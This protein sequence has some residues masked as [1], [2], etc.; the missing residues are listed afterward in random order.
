[1][2]LL[3]AG[4]GRI[5]PLRATLDGLGES[6]LVVGGD[7]LWNVHVHV[8]DVGAAVEA[9]VAAGRPH[10]IRVTHLAAGAARAEGRRVVAV[11]VGDG[12]ATLFQESAAV[13]VPG[14]AGRRASIAEVLDGIRRTVA[15]EVVVLPNDADSLAVAEAAARAARAEGVR[16]AV[17]PSR[18]SVQALAALAVHEPHR[19][20]DDDVVSMTAA[21][22]HARHG[23]V[24]VATRDGVTMA[25]VCSTGDVLGVIDGD[26]AVIG[27]R[28]DATACT[29]VDRLLGGGG[30]LVTLLVGADAEDSL[31]AAVVEH[32][33]RTRP[34]VETVVYAGGQPR[35]PL[36][37]GVE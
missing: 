22:G 1:M 37:V 31:A 3:D 27:A 23:G 12:L 30:E 34:E 13:V 26:F 8:D 4:E 19:L 10:R 29:V 2:Y 9:G 21:A 35:Y 20:F 25:G 5:P 14:G 16:V 18:A 11:V 36:L 33:H 32:L 24:T 7:G 15:R 28:L 17:V 6:L